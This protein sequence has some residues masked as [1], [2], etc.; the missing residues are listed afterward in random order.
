MIIPKRPLAETEKSW[1]VV[2]NP[3]KGELAKTRTV[4]VLSQTFSLS[5]EEASQLVENAPLIL[6]EDLSYESAQK[7]KYH[8]L[9]C[10]LEIHLTNNPFQKRK[11]F[12]TVW[13]E[14]PRLNFLKSESLSFDLPASANAKKEILSSDQAL[15]HIREEVTQ[16]ETSPMKMIDRQDSDVTRR[17]YEDLSQ[18]HDLL[19]EEKLFQDQKIEALEREIRFLRDKENST[20]G[21]L[22]TLSLERENLLHELEALKVKHELSLKQSETQDNSLEKRLVFLESE[23]SALRE[24]FEALRKEYEDAERLWTEKLK[25]KEESWR[26][27]EN[28]LEICRNRIAELTQRLEVSER[29]HQKN[30]FEEGLALRE[31]AL[32][33]LVSRQHEFE[34]E[35][36]EKERLLRTT[37][38]E[39]EKLEKEIVKG[40]QLKNPS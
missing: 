35:I 32:K 13:P 17:R 39:Q 19:L 12:R 14:E 5:E 6:L 1:S 8:F 28:E 30:L 20:A 34:K 11:C 16:N 23:N 40:K 3:I 21:S 33:D 18:K 22:K 10:G 31:K 26:S 25:T 2:L 29:S 7:I 15:A 9:E 27:L 36:T 24:R 4:E 37:L 38:S